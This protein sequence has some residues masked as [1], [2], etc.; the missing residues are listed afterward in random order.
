MRSNV[1]LPGQSLADPGTLKTQQD[2]NYWLDEKAAPSGGDGGGAADLTDI[3]ARLEVIEKALLP[4]VEFTDANRSLTYNAGS[5]Y[6]DPAVRMYQY[7]STSSA[8]EWTWAWMVQFPGESEWTDVDDMTAEQQASI[9]YKGQEEWCY[10]Y[11][12]PPD[13]ADMLDITVKLKITDS[14]E[15]FDDAE[16]WS[17]PFMPKDTWVNQGSFSAAVAA[18]A[19]RKSGRGA[20][21]VPAPPL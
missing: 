8:G 12:T 13:E 5:N 3:E 16:G 19:P 18:S 9:G 10:L 7:W 4:W 21:Q 15:G 11:L 17:D 1:K 2:V 20:S 6:T 14:L